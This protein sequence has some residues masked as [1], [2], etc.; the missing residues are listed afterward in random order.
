LSHKCC[1]VVDDAAICCKNVRFCHNHVTSFEM[2]QQYVVKLLDFVASVLHTLKS[3]HHFSCY[4]PLRC[5]HTCVALFTMLQQLWQ[6]RQRPLSC[7]IL[8]RWPCCNL[9][10]TTYSL[11]ELAAKWDDAS[12]CKYSMR[13]CNMLWCILFF[14]FDHFKLA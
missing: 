8:A 10:L 13:V 14:L 1:I 6:H 9:T 3:M 11:W 4:K 2:L 7:D 5:C 12:R